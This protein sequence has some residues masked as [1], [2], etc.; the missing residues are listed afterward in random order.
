MVVFYDPPKKGIQEVFQHIYD[1]GI[2]VKVITGDN[3]DTTKSIA[4][5]A[6]IINTTDAVEVKEIMAYSEERLLQE[7]EEKYY[8]QECSLMPSL[9]S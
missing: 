5:Q 4:Q 6:G 8:S 2:K 1:A 3:M 9:W 7:V